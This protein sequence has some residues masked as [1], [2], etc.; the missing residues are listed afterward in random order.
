MM[1]HTFI[2]LTLLVTYV[3]GGER[4]HVLTMQ[5]SLATAELNRQSDSKGIPSLRPYEPFDPVKDADRLHK[6]MAGSGTDEQ[7][8][9]DVLAHRTHAQRQDI[10]AEFEKKYKENFRTW[11][12]GEISGWFATTIRY[13]MEGRISMIAEQ[14]ESAMKGAGTDEQAL[15]NILLPCNA[16]DLK[17]IKIEFKKRTTFGLSE[18][19]ADETSGPFRQ[20]L[21]DLVNAK[22]PTSNKVDKKLAEQ[23]GQYLYNDASSELPKN[24]N[25]ILTSRSWPQL[26]ETF[27][28]FVRASKKE[29]R[30][31]MKEKTTGWHQKALEQIDTL[32][33]YAENSYTI[34]APELYKAFKLKDEWGIIR[35][36]VGQAEINLKSIDQE[37][38]RIYGAVMS[39]AEP[40]KKFRNPAE[41]RDTLLALLGEK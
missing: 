6:A 41:Y 10:Q 16:D 14:L 31:V 24:M 11:L 15:L 39:I 34:Y 5:R 29:F 3:H 28:A 1:V 32:A 2:S 4:S 36:I 20:L 26:R 33:K 7:T 40:V 22:R 19:I 35:I 30:L 23:E 13:M 17:E 12:Y 18:R 38:K 25:K 27:Q 9:I 37:Y 8:I 21:L